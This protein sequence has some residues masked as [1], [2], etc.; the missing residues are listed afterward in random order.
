[1]PADDTDVAYILGHQS[2]YEELR[3][4]LRSLRFFPHRKVWI[5]GAPPPDWSVG[6]NWIPVDQASTDM[7]FRDGKEWWTNR[8]TNMRLNLLA[9]L[10]SPEV[11]DTFLYM[12]DDFILTRPWADEPLSHLGTF[13]ETHKGRIERKQGPY[14]DLYHW[15]VDHGVPQPLHVSEHVPLL[16]DQRLA[17]MMRDVWHIVGFPYASL[18]GNLT[19]VELQ[20]AGDWVLNHEKDH[21]N[22]WPDNWWSLSTVSNSFHKWP[23]GD[24]V[25]ALHP[26]PSPYE[27]PEFPVPV[28]PAPTIP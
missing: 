15:F 3:Y 19:D 5:A 10:D 7:R 2:E 6:L 11:S 27:N 1:M 22:G 16:V 21:K 23:V 28:N 26:D 4:S 8:K 18:W 24:K 9:L 17:Q 20:K 25:R 14:V 12:N 13:Q